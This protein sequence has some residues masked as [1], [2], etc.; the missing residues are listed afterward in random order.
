MTGLVWRKQNL[1]TFRIAELARNRC[2][3]I[4][5]EKLAVI[6]RLVK[7][8]SDIDPAQSKEAIRVADTPGMSS[9]THMSWSKLVK[10]RRLV[11]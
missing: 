10:P 2:E 4:K 6:P 3:Q 9:A 11:G 5:D 1:A 7:E 8:F